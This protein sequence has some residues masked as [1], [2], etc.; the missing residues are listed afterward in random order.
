MHTHNDDLRSIVAHTTAEIHRYQSLL[1]PLE[2]KRHNAQLELDSLVYPVLTL[3]PEI[4]SG[5]FI[6]CLDRGPNNSMECREAPMLLLHVCRA[7][8]DVAVSTPAL[9]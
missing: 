2:E 6:H 4:T 3:P 5:I 9:W 7:W 1:R 8:R